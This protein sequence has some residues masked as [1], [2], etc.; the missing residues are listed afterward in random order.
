MLAPVMRIVSMAVKIVRIQFAH[1]RSPIKESQKYL[2]QNIC[3]FEFTAMKEHLF[4]RLRPLLYSVSGRTPNSTWK[5]PYYLSRWRW[6]VCR[7]LWNSFCLRTCEMSLY[8]RFSSWLKFLMKIYEIC[9]NLIRSGQ[10]PTRLPLCWVRLLWNWANI[11]VVWDR[12]NRG[13]IFVANFRF[14]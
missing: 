13:L 11:C 3:C 8:G 4:D 10:V 1:A 9:N 5:V 2:S 14:L 12:V 6:A 7:R